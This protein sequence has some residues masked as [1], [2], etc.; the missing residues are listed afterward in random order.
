LYRGTLAAR[1]PINAEACK[2]YVRAELVK[3]L[4]PDDIVV[5][6]NPNSHQ[7]KVVRDLVKAIGARRFFLPS[8]GPDLKAIDPSAGSGGLRKNQAR[9]AKGY[10]P[11][12][13]SRRKR[14]CQ[15]PRHHHTPGMLELPRKCR[16]QPKC[17]TL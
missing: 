3:T 9:D 15:N 17:E 13:R 10:G 14:R 6:D 5:L 2:T 12:R 8:Y 7:G 4:N 1:C 16:I 11:K